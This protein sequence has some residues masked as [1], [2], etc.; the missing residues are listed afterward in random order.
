MLRS[1]LDNTPGLPLEIVALNAG[2][3]LYASGIA[4]DIADGIVRARDAIASGAARA[5]LAQFVEATRRL[6]REAA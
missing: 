6:A 3:A 5:K 2:A 1:A 4:G